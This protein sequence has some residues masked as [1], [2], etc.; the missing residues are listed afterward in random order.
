MSAT[1]PRPFAVLVLA[2]A[3]WASPDACTAQE[4]SLAS[5]F[6]ADAG[7]TSSSERTRIAA[8]GW[9]L[10]APDLRWLPRNAGPLSLHWDLSIGAWRAEC[11][12]G[13]HRTFTQL[14]GLAVWRHGLGAQGS[15]WFVDIGLGGVLFDHVYA[16]RSRRFSTAFQFTQ[17]LGLGYRFGPNGTYEVSARAQHVSN[18]GLKKPNPGEN[19]LRLRLAMGF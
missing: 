4:S 7:A 9:L 16:A 18:G 14:A 3:A 1:A 2:L 8:L 5:R 12:D 17:A 15:G 6:Y 19:L 13:G 10:P 11:A